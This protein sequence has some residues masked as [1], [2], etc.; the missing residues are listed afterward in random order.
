[1]YGN[2]RVRQGEARVIAE[3]GGC[4]AGGVGRWCGEGEG[5]G[6]Q[7]CMLHVSRVRRRML[8]G[9]GV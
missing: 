6:M 5:K 2:M 1:M 4:G 3:C 8:E 9:G 7:K